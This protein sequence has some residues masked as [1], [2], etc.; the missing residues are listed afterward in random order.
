MKF[1][2]R[3]QL[4]QWR[5]ET[6]IQEPG[7]VETR[8]DFRF[9]YYYALFTT[10]GSKWTNQNKVASPERSAYFTYNNVMYFFVKDRHKWFTKIKKKYRAGLLKKKL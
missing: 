6:P 3:T 5:R 8:L 1:H 10:L 7:K 9:F 4:Y 2:L